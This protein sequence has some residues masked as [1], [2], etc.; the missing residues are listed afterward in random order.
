MDDKLWIKTVRTIQKAGGFPIPVNNT[1]IELTQTL[2]NEEEASFILNFKK[3]SLNI[4]Q[5]K[6]KTGLDEKYLEKMLTQLMD[7]GII[8]GA[9]SRST[10]IMVYSLMP[11]LPGIF[12]FSFMKGKTGE[13]EKKLARIYEKLHEELTEYTQNNY[14]SFVEQYINTPLMDR[15]VP[16]DQEIEIEPET[17]VHFEDIKKLVESVDEIAVSNCY[18]RHH[19][20]LLDEHCKINAPKLNCFQLGKTATFAIEHGFAKSVSKEEA[21][22]ILREAEDA[23]LVHKIIHVGINPDNIE[24]GICSCC[25]DCCI[26]FQLYYR[27]IAPLKS[28]TSYIAKVDA[29]ICSGCGT[30]V[31]RCPVEA[32]ELINT[33]AVINVNRCIGCGV[34]A[35]FCPEK[36]IKLERTGPRIVF[37]SP[38]KIKTT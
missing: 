20:D 13:R 2:M 25:K 18:C 11:F 30:C 19:K 36:A 1:T 33:T 38:P 22:K 4:D 32:P 9:Q 5:L 7:K 21:I 31:E 14:D 35:H 3:P 12:E 37:V 27:G 24:A 29:D 23:G 8:I 6:D 10:G 28:L 26:S 15:V 17:V 16:V 34:C